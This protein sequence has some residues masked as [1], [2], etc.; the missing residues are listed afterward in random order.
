MI[1]EKIFGFE[2]G[3]LHHEKENCSYF[4]KRS[5]F[6]IKILKRFVC[7]YFKY[8]QMCLLILYFTDFLLIFLIS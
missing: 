1:K 3:K 5:F 6:N 7:L 8:K 4:L 2:D